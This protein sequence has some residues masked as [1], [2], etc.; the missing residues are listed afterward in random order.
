MNLLERYGA[1]GD[2]FAEAA[3]YPG[4]YLAR[5]LSQT[6]ELYRIVTAEGEGSGEVSGKLRHSM[7]QP[8]YIPLLAILSS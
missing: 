8:C 6:K 7:R 1:T 5:I 4:L 3:F 2:R